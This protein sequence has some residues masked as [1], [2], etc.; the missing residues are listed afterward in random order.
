MRTLFD[1]YRPVLATPGARSL[2]LVGLL[3]RLPATGRSI[4]L[5]LHVVLDQHL[6]YGA[7]GLVGM[8]MTVG[9]AIGSPIAG[10]VMDR[11]GLRPVLLVT[12][13]AELAYW[14]SVPFLPYAVLLPATLVGGTLAVPVFGLLRLA[15]AATL[16]EE[17][18]RQGFALDSMLVELAFMIGPAAAVAA[19]TTTHS[20]TWTLLGIGALTVVSVVSLW[21]LDPP[22]GK[23]RGASEE[24]AGAAGGTT[25]D[26]PSA[27]TGRRMWLHPEFVLVLAVC[28]AASLVLTGTDVSIVATLRVLGQTQWSGVAIIAWCAASLVGGF[29]HGSTARPWR[30]PVLMLALGALTVP[31]GLVGHLG[32]AWLCLALLPAGF[33]CAPTIASTVEAV[34]SAVPEAVR[35]QAMGLQGSAMTLGGSIGAPLAG[36]VID[37][38]SAAWGYAVAGGIGAVL[39]ATMLGRQWL[40]GRGGGS[41]GAGQTPAREVPVAV[42]AA[43]APV[44]AVAVA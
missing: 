22:V 9:F 2:F 43:P 15:V 21:I 24:G 23:G 17:R 14:I 6:G 8:A 40:G 12:G 42:A 36:T 37:H 3:A 33:V 26:A 1:P 25:A 20:G 35:G 5:T 27:K 39:A 11:R 19:V 18:R 41:T 31:V 30:L 7:A 10:R 29:W 38:G 28:M 32:W 13:T 16:P 34:S 44:E 4:A